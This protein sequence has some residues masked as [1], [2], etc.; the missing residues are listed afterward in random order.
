MDEPLGSEAGRLPAPTAAPVRE[1]GTVDVGR[2]QAA[3]AGHHP[4]DEREEAARRHILAALDRLP[5]PFD[6]A[7]DLTH[8]TASGIVVG[9]PGVVLHRHRRLGRWMQPGGHIEPGETP[10]DAVV[11]ECIEETGLPVA[12][13]GGQPVLVHLDVHEA[14]DS[15]VHL[16]LRYL[17][18]APGL[19]PAPG[20]GESPDVAW[21]GWEEARSLADEALI[22]A[23]RAAERLVRAGRTAAGG[24]LGGLAEP[25]GA[26]EWS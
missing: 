20:P 10:E 3:V 7:A 17:L 24:A 15:H 12:H 8:V 2:V 1:V 18:V 11:R 23:V 22:G 26:E 21:F 9:P 5:R 25:G 14:S 4:G 6:A 19:P 16:D 13:P